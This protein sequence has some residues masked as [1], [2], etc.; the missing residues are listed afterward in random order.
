MRTLQAVITSLLFLGSACHGSDDE[1]PPGTPPGEPPGPPGDRQDAGAGSPP[2]G[3]FGATPGGVKDMRY[4]RALITEGKVPPKETLLVEGMFA[5]HE[6]GL[7]GAACEDVLCLR[8]AA[9]VAPDGAGSPRGWVEV[10]LSSTIDPETWTRPAT[11]FIFT[12]DVSGSMGWGYGEEDITPGHLARI[13]LHALTDQLRADDEVAIVTYGEDVST[14]LSI[15]AGGDHATVHAVIDDL[16]EAGSTNM[17]AGMR[18]AYE[19]GAA[20]AARGRANVR[21][22]LFSDEQPNVGATGSTEFETLIADG[23]DDGVGITVLALGLGVGAELV[24]SMSHLRGANAF[25]FADD[26]DAAQFMNDD[27]PWFTTPIAYDLSLAVTPSPDLGIAE[28]YG[29][30]GTFAADPELTVS[31]IFLSKR[32]GAVFSIAA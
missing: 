24:Q 26:N 7:T 14:A 6:L 10:G 1:S 30:P 11:T 31:T 16:E 15:T 13:L 27:Y 19:L 20:A 8:A 28:A 21:V 22:I 29:F 4:A 32:K 2:G 17:E 12:V 5:E 25:S 3:D 18:R 23:A 9:G